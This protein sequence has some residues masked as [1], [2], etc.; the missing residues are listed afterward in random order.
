M[1][2]GIADLHRRAQVSQAANARYLEALAATDTSTSLGKLLSDIERPVTFKRRRVRGLRAWSHDDLALFRAANRGEFCITGF[3]NRDLQALLYDTTAADPQQARRR[4][5]RVGR[6]IRMLRAH[7]LVRKVPRAHR[8]RVTT[9]GRQ[10]L[11]AV[12]AAQ[13][14]TLQQRSTLASAA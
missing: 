7:G 8:Y 1:R 14:A 10:V 6:Q 12:L 5:S 13:E 9:K 11:T 3:R 4:S 2:K